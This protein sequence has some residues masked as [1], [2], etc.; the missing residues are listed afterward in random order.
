[1]ELSGRRWIGRPWG[2]VQCVPGLGAAGRATITLRGRKEEVRTTELDHAERVGFFR[3]ILGPLD[4]FGSWTVSTSARAA[5]KEV[6]RELCSDRG[7]RN[8]RIIVESQ[9]VRSSMPS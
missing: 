2:D 6:Y 4:S 1:M 9:S 5:D 7:V 3:D 8:F